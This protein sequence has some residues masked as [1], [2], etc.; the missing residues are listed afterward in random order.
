MTTTQRGTILQISEIDC[1]HNSKISS[2]TKQLDQKFLDIKYRQSHSSKKSV[3]CKNCTT[4]L[5]I[6]TIILKFKKTN[7]M[8][9][10]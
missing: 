3:H 6:L 2:K 5:K 8:A 1:K 7:K 9:L 4:N 10:G